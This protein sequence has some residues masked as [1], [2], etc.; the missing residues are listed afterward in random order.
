MNILRNLRCLLALTFGTSVLPHAHAAGFSTLEIPTSHGTV[1]ARWSV[2]EGLSLFPTL[3]VIPDDLGFTPWFDAKVEDLV[4]KGFGVL[5]VDIFHGK[6]PRETEAAQ[7][8]LRESG[9]QALDEL[10]SGVVYLEKLSST[11]GQKVGV[12]GWSVG[13]ELA[14]KL[15]ASRTEIA[16]CVVYY[17]MPP[18]ERVQ[19]E[20]LD[21]PIF[22]CFGAEDP[23]IPL[24]TVKKFEQVLKDLKK[25]GAVRIYERAG[26]F[27]Q[28]VGR[29][30]YNKPAS[31]DAW[32]RG[33][34]F[35]SNQLEPN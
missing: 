26:H 29:P 27:F 20:K 21:T 31:E 25:K 22:A 16:G 24:A 6:P 19:I 5:C 30:S 32:K 13:G 28:H 2:P 11:S 3:L 23:V 18:S 33:V 4:G 7:A 10:V 8:W 12:I 34:T 9:S 14:F 1:N 15:I 35:L 17:G